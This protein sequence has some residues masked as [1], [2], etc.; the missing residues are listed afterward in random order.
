M[1]LTRSPGGVSGW[2]FRRVISRTISVPGVPA[3]V[4]PGKSN[5][6]ALGMWKGYSS[7]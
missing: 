5:R 2:V 4:I 3:M 7:M 1:T 6:M